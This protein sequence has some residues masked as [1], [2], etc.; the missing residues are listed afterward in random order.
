MSMTLAQVA[1]LATFDSS[2]FG[3]D[4]SIRSGRNCEY[5][6][7]RQQDSLVSH[8]DSPSSRRWSTRGAPLSAVAD[9][10]FTR[11][12]G[13]ASYELRAHVNHLPVGN[14]G[15]RHAHAARGVVTSA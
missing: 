4:L 7:S 12:S 5:P 14:G 13:G 2:S 10:A 3:E 9:P 8:R 6:D 1:M 11:R 15:Q